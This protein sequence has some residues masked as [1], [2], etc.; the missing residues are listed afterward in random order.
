[1]YQLYEIIYFPMN[2]ISIGS[3]FYK[4]KSDYPFVIY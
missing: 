3:D 4:M 2:Q 1:M